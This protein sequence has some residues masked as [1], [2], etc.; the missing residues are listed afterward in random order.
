MVSN[1][2]KHYVFKSLFEDN[3]TQVS[4]D[5]GQAHLCTLSDIVHDL[6]QHISY[7]S[8]ATRRLLVDNGC[9]SP[10]LCNPIQYC[11]ACRN[12]SIPPDVKMSSKN[13]LRDSSWQTL[14]LKNVSTA[15]ARCSSDQRC[16][17]TEGFKPLYP[18]MCVSPRHLQICRHCAKFKSYNCFCPTLCIYVWFQSTAAK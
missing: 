7:S 4:S 5:E 10:E 18:A 8:R 15:N 3:I 9:R 6:P 12:L 17:M 2:E 1:M 11:L 14:F 16:M 13:T